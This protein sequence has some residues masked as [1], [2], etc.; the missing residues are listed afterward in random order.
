LIVVIVAIL[1]FA[2][3]NNSNEAMF[4]TDFLLDFFSLRNLTSTAKE[5]LF[6]GVVLIAYILLKLY[7]EKLDQE[8]L[9]AA[10]AMEE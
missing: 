6:L 9:L 8:E 5:L 3:A 10:K 1:F 4:T 7:N 2:G